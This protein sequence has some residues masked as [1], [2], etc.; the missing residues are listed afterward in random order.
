MS[1]ANTSNVRT[2]YLYR[3]FL[4]YVPS[5]FREFGFARGNFPPNVASPQSV[6]RS[7]VSLFPTPRKAVMFGNGPV[8]FVLSPNSRTGTF[9][10]Y[11]GEGLRVI[12]VRTSHP[13]VVILSR[14]TSQS[15]CPGLVRRLR[16]S[17]CLPS[18]AVRRSRVQGPYGTIGFSIA[19]VDRPSNRGLF[20]TN[21]V[22]KSLCPFSLRLA[23][24]ATFK[25]TFFVGCRKSRELGTASVKGVMDFR[26]R[27]IFRSRPFFRLIGDSSNS[28]FLP[29]SPFSILN[30]CRANVFRNGLCRF[31]LYSLLQ[32]PSICLLLSSS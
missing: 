23:M 29:P 8:N 22:I 12:R 30:G 13:V 31:F 2:L 27:R 9:T 5:V 19:L 16:D 17:V 15:T 14:A 32:S 1:L 26:T 18:S 10:K 20:R 6:V 11:I 28:S 21:V 4:Q 3:F 24:V 7:E 25:A